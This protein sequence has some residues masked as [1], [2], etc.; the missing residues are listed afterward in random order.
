MADESEV[1]YEAFRKGITQD[2]RPWGAFRRF[3][4]AGVSSAKI[5]TV[6]PGGVLSLQYHDRRDEFWVIL[7]DGLEMTLGDRVWRPARGEEIWI[8]RGTHHRI[9]GVSAR[10][11][12]FFELWVGESNENDIVRVEDIYKR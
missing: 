1:R 4:L 3:P 6:E 11:A 5:I 12:R 8:P 7:D 10:T 2:Q 9:R